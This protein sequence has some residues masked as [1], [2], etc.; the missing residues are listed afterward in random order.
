MH[1]NQLLSKSI[2]SRGHLEK[3][4]PKICAA[5]VVF[6]TLAYVKFR[7]TCRQKIAMS[8]NPLYKMC[9]FPEKFSENMGVFCTDFR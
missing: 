3:S 6:E 1:P 8:G 5:S 9:F 4:S 7:P 2:H